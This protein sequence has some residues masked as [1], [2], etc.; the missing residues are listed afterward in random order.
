MLKPSISTPA[1]IGFSVLIA[2]FLLLLMVFCG[3]AATQVPW[4]DT[5][6]S[7]AILKM[8]TALCEFKSPS[9]DKGFVQKEDE[10]LNT[11]PGHIGDA[12]PDAPVGRLAIGAEAPLR[13]ERR[14]WKGN[15]L[16]L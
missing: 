11:L 3:V 16:A 8:G 12:E 14:Y 1:M 10:L 6:N 15:G 9:D 2:I 4:V 7:Y 13:W 5:L